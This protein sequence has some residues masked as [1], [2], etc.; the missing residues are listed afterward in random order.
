MNTEQTSKNIFTYKVLSDEIKTKLSGKRVHLS[1]IDHA[2]SANNI[3]KFGDKI[4]SENLF[5]VSKC[6]NRQGPSIFYGWFKLSGNL[7][8]YGTY[9]SKNDHL[10][11]QAENYG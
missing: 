4:K 5:F 3:L 6:I 2:I 10:N 7:H 1:N 9:W 11:I 8:S